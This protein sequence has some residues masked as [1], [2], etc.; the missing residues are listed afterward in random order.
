MKKLITTFFFSSFMFLGYGANQTT[1]VSPILPGSELPF[2]VSVETAD[3]SLPQGLQSYVSAVHE[4]KVLLFAGLIQG[5]HGFKTGRNTTAFVVDLDK[6][7]TVSRSLLDPASGLTPAQI[8]LLSVGNAQYMQTDKSLYITGGYGIDTSSGMF[9]TK[10]CLTAVDIGAMIHWVTHPESPKLLAPHIK[11]IFDD[12]FKVAGGA[13]RKGKNGMALLIFGADTEG[14]ISTANPIYTEQVRRFFIHDH[15]K[16]LSV[17]FKDPI[18]LIPD[19]NY[20][21]RDLNVVPI[22]R[23]HRPSFVALSGVFTLSN[24]IWTV[25]VVISDTGESKMANPANPKTFKQGM[26]NYECASAELFSQRTNDMYILLFG[27]ISYGFF[28]DGVFVESTSLPFINQITTVKINKRGNFTQYIMPAEFPV[29]LSTTVNPGNPL[30]FGADAKFFPA[31]HIKH[32]PNGVLSFDALPK[33]KNFIGYIIGGI[34]STLPNTT[35]AAD[36]GAS[37]YIFE[38]YLTPAS[39]PP[40]PC[41]ECSHPLN[42]VK[43]CLKGCRR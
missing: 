2:A 34:Q 43:K 14:P 26:N 12:N 25:P 7:T 29:I 15:G 3:F 19:P 41:C 6:G 23:N 21:R 17:T 4:N 28:V 22:L 20:R 9:T 31:H 40:H 36:S 32:F 38:V 37:P 16:K 13:M 8:D 18:P 33:K 27:G 42:V 39:E 11:Q 1:T 35:S 10:N 24:G 30:L 5:K